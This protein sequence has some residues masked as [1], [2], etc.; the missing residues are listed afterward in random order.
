MKIYTKT[1]DKG[2]TGLYGNKRVDKDCINIQSIG[3]L[4][5]LNSSLGI[6]KSVCNHNELSYRLEIIQNWLFEAGSEIAT[7]LVHP[8]YKKWITSEQIIQLEN[9]IDNMETS[10]APLSNFILPGGS[11]LS[12][13][14]QLS[15]SI[16]RRAERSLIN[17]NRTQDI[18]HEI[19]VFLNRLSDWLFV[20]SRFSNKLEKT[21]DILWKGEKKDFI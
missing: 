5:E 11:L 14:L 21:K 10:L 3:D 1:G 20:A 17:L 8:K 6:C 9:D 15:R 12:S 4:D 2:Q 13:H 19:L 7:P 18:N 16:C